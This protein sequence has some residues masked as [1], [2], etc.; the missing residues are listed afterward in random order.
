[1]TIADA[2]RRGITASPKAARIVKSDPVQLLIQ[3]QRAARALDSPFRF[4]AAEIATRR[5]G[6]YRLRS[7]G[8]PVVLRHRSRDVAI[9]N[10]VFGGSGGRLAYAPPLEASGM[11][12]GRPIRVLDL[13]GN[14]G[15][16][17]LYALERWDVASLTSFE[18]EPDNLR[19]LSA[20][21][22]AQ[23]TAWSAVGAA[24][25]NH[26]GTIGFTTGLEADAHIADAGE[27][28]VEVPMVD[29]FGLDLAAD[30][31]KI[32]I[33]GGEWPILADARFSSLE[34]PVL[35]M[36]WHA[37]DCPDEQPR[38]FIWDLMAGVGYQIVVDQLDYG[39]NNGMVWAIK[40]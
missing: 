31:I 15:L 16:F 21:I 26:N 30:L 28:S 2:A 29:F 13:G 27:Q 34:I 36:E 33:E 6:R 7:S 39:G 25:S 18:P 32:D 38:S 12:D 1:M 40:P 5:A 4:A 10:E 11:L 20:N 17:G 8:R 37:R 24:V 22:A 3:T 14:I 9:F 35:V 23:S 19:V